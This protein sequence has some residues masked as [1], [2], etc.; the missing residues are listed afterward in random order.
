MLD[1]HRLSFG[2]ADQGLP[3]PE[4][5]LRRMEQ[6][7]STSFADV[8]VHLGPE[9]ASLGAHA[10]VHGSDIYIERE[11]FDPHSADGWGLI[12]HELAH[13]KQSRRGWLLAPEGLGVRLLVDPALEAEA[14]RMGALARRAFKPDATLPMA[15]RPA[16]TP[17]RWDLL[18]ASLRS[19]R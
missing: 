12:G 2:A 10:F 17:P 18:L 13:V 1:I 7:F 9:P 15:R 11:L 19:R 6:L 3:L 14:D 4:C 16:P 8:R 5:M